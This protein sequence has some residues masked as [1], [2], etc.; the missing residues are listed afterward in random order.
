MDF[1]EIKPIYLQIADKIMDDILAGI[2]TEQSRIPSVREYAASVE[3][4]ANTVM[5][6]YDYLSQRNILFNRRGIG[7][8]VETGAKEHILE[9]RRATFFASEAKFFM[10][11]L[12][13]F[14]ITPDQL[15]D[16]YSSYLYA[17][18]DK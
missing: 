8:F 7:F 5:R 6:T 16:M 14:G 4:N 18:N 10:G 13:S 12:A 3:V 9:M 15:R 2:Y 1:Q 17:T 11:R